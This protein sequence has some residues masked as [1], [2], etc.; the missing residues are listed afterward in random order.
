MLTDPPM[1]RMIGG[2]PRTH[3][4]TRNESTVQMIRAQL[5]PEIPCRPFTMNIANN[6]PIRQRYLPSVRRSMENADDAS[7]S[8]QLP[9]FTLLDGKDT[10]LAATGCAARVRPRILVG[11]PPSSRSSGA[12]Q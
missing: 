7:L 12:P 6:G 5:P 1:N 2:R 4:V 9:R 3:S 8:P 11:G 10:R